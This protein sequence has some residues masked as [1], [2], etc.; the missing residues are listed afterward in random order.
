MCAFF[1]F[2]HSCEILSHADG[3]VKFWDASGSA[4]QILYKLKTGKI[5]ERPKSA[6][7]DDPFAVTMMSWCPEGRFL[8]VA[9]ASSQVLL[10]TFHKH[11]VTSHVP[12]SFSVFFFFLL[13]NG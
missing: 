2:F 13:S 6:S 5:F 9:G 1:F 3:S 4:L 7:G 8:A 12:V 10:F 11:E